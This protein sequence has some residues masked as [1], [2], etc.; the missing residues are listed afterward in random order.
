VP[1]DQFWFVV[2]GQ[3]VVA[4]RQPEIAAHTHHL[5]EDIDRAV[6]GETDAHEAIIY[7]RP[8]VAKT[9]RLCDVHFPGIQS[10]AG[11]GL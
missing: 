8:V 9:G 7:L 3:D 2:T 1:F 5:C 4:G 11:R 10:E 6:S